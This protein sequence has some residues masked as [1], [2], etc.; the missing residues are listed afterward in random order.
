MVR[1]TLLGLVGCTLVA[2]PAF[3]TDG[4]VSGTTDRGRK[5]SPRETLKCFGCHTTPATEVA[6]ENGAVLM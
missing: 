3:A 6:V 2:L 1:K 4:P 5:L